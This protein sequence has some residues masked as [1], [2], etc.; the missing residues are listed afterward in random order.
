MGLGGS[1]QLGELGGHSV[2]FGDRCQHADGGLTTGQ[3]RTETVPCGGV[4]PTVRRR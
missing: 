2:G 1:A 3:F 4:C